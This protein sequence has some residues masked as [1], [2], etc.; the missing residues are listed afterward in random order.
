M[1]LVA[2]ASADAQSA[3]VPD[4]AGALATTHPARVTGA[5]G[6]S[7]TT[8]I[9][10]A[11]LSTSA[12]TVLP[13]ITAPAE[14]S[15]LLGGVPFTLGPHEGDTWLVSLRLPARTP[16]GDYTV[17]LRANDSAGRTL[18][19]DSLV[20][21]VP[22][23]HAV[24]LLVTERPIYAISGATYRGA[25]LVRNLGNVAAT[26]RLTSRSSLGGRTTAPDSIALAAGESRV[27]RVAVVTTLASQES[28]D[29]AVQLRATDVADSAAT[30]AASMQVTIVQRADASVP[31]LRVAST[32]RLRASDAA[33]G[34]S[35]FELI[36]GGQLR[37]GHSDQLEF[38]MRGRASVSTPFGDQEEYRVGLRGNSYQ[39]QIGDAFFNRSPLT[40]IGQRG[41]GAG[42]KLN[43]HNV[44]V[45]GFTQRF[46]LAPE[47]SSESGAAIH[48]GGGE[49]IGAQ[50]LGFGAVRR[51]GGPLDAQILSANTTLHPLGD[52][53][54]ELEYAD[55]RG[56]PGHGVASSARVSGGDVVHLELGY[57]TAEPT[58]AGVMRGATSQFL[59]L[60]TQSWN[61]VQLLAAANE[62]RTAGGRGTDLE[63][64]QRNATMEVLYD[65]RLSLTYAARSR[66]SDVLFGAGKA[67]QRGVTA[68]AE[69][70]LGSARVWGA[71]EVGRA[72][73]RSG[74]ARHPF[75][76]LSLGGSAA[77]G[78]HI[79]SLYGETSQGSAISR[80]ADR[81]N[82]LGYDVQLQ[83]APKTIVSV[84]GSD[85]RTGGG[86][87]YAQMD[88]RVTHQL[89]T[90]ASVTMRVRI[91][92][93][94]FRTAADGP[95]QAFMEYS[96]PLQLPIGRTH[97]AGRVRGRVVDQAT[98]RGISGTLVRLGT[99]AAITDGEGQVAFAGLPAGA[100]R[101]SLAQQASGNTIFTGDPTVQIDSARREAASFRVAVEPAGAV[102]GTVRQKIVARTGLGVQPDSIVDGGPLE[103]VSVAL[104]GARDTIYRTSDARGEFEFS[105]VSSGAWTVI[106]MGELP[107][108]TQWE[109]ERIPLVLERGGAERVAFRLV[110]RRRRVRIVSGDGIDE[111]K[112]T[113]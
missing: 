76:A 82:T 85:T 63:S 32:L 71:G 92:G 22:P 38:V 36:G 64:R 80:G 75:G 59:S 83:M 41:F 48:F 1:M 94:D 47:P 112:E 51:Q 23:R 113:P 26:F 61:R 30:A 79:V 19:R 81:Q 95:K 10:V 31:L 14:W 52:L 18:M 25:V 16:A 15:T 91:G 106:V 13:H 11:N 65:S 62:Y 111:V 104:A 107:A 74:D 101:L 109:V 53:A 40:G 89:P 57:L 108:Q 78:R 96:M 72:T 12:L 5:A 45:A 110:P 50:R 97:A 35:P 90:G 46:R 8:T 69:Q 100:Y 43:R 99:Q 103:G 58:F 7:I 55:S 20:V 39:A 21:T 44:G 4:T 105:D 27:V 102:R 24:A 2:A 17:L 37:D 33:T 77:V 9:R 88:A 6:T 93:Q 73:D 84:G 60:N 28:F 67:S 49:D 34:V 86:V 98:G 42:L 56:V 54:V 66:Y 3:A 70:Q 68:R 87:G 29:D